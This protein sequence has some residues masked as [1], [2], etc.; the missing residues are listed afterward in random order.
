MRLK[1]REVG[2]SPGEGL[3]AQ[4]N[5][6]GRET[7]LEFALVVSCEGALIFSEHL[8]CARNWAKCFT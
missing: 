1:P 4:T 8:P 7:C 3:F 6:L 5:D 2:V